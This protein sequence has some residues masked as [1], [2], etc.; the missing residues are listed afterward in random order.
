VL[1]LWPHKGRVI[2]VASGRGVRRS[3][4]ALFVLALLLKPLIKPARR[5]HT[6]RQQP[7]P[8]VPMAL[9]VSPSS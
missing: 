5:T 4:T 6:T 3:P 9:A 8:H 2:A 1:A 7:P